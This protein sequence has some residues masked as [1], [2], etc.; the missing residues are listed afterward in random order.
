MIKEEKRRVV[1]LRSLL[2]ALCV[3]CGSISFAAEPIRV[4]VIGLDTSHAPAFVKVLNDPK[5]EPDVAG[6]RVVAAYPPGS[7]DIPSSTKRVPQYT[8]DLKKLGV[9]IVESIDELLKRVDV[10]LLESNDG[11]PHAEQVLPVLKA[12]KPVFVDKPVAGCLADAIRIYEAAD[13][14]K[15]PIFSSSALRFNPSAQALRAGKAGKVLGAEAYSPCELE[16][17]HPDFYWYGVHG[18]ET[19]Y[20]V[21][22]TGCRTVVRVSTPNDDVAVGTWDD[23]RVG[24]FRGL[25]PK[26]IAGTD[27][28]T[29]TGYG[30]TVFGEKAI[31][32]IGPSPGYRPLVAQIAQFFRT[33]KSPIDSKE[34]LEIY[35][36]MEAADES[37][38][39]GGIPVPVKEVYERAAAEA[40]KIPLR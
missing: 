14:F 8:A 19:L 7:K 22:G 18:V 27:K 29:V 1:I 28:N 5:A 3:L 38:H 20:T 34:T 32:P 36:F 4:G 33:G 23:G 9:E 26:K 17:H 15:V 13:H 30:G 25:R 10:V 2:G 37:K 39:R 16:K 11:R 40:A 31:E 35:A 12:G 6:F 24:T 21:M